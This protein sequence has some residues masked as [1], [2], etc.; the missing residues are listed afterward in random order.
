MR[1]EAASASSAV[2]PLDASG[3]PLP[4]IRKATMSSSS[5]SSSSF[6][7]I[8]RHAPHPCLGTLVCA[9]GALCAGGGVG[10]PV[11]AQ[12]SVPPLSG[13]QVEQVSGGPQAT[14]P[15]QVF[16]IRGFD[17]D[18]QVGLAPERLGQVQAVFDALRGPRRTLAEV[19]AARLSAQ[20]LLDKAQPDALAVNV[21]AQTLDNGRIRVVIARLLDMRVGQMR[22]VAAPGF[23]ERNVRAS[24]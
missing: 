4:P 21:P 12:N 18:D 15:A 23:D 8:R 6:L 13:R 20:S 16:E 3:G 2:A 22:A 1:T 17:L 9:A 7:S 5:F 10:F 11:R 14:A 19:T 24:A